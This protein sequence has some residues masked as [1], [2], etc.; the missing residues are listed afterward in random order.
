MTNTNLWRLRGSP[1]TY[2]RENDWALA[3]KLSAEEFGFKPYS[4]NSSASMFNNSSWTFG[5][6]ESS[7]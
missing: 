3:L 2:K 7:Q 6:E 5:D 4:D 1:S